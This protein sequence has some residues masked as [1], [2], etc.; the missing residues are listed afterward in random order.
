M[1]ERNVITR[2][3]GGGAVKEP[4][5][6]EG[7]NEER[8]KRWPNRRFDILI[9]PSRRRGGRVHF[10]YRMTAYS[11]LRQS[12]ASR[13]VGACSREHPSM[14]MSSTPAW[15]FLYVIST[16]ISRPSLHL[17]TTIFLDAE[18]HISTPVLA[19][20]NCLVVSHLSIS[21]R[22]RRRISDRRDFR[23]ST[24]LKKIWNNFLFVG[25]AGE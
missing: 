11:L 13:F 1:W 5:K 19:P 9:Y 2:V 25:S 3:K 16:S 4:E 22:E 24:I 17:R 15:R 6:K 7:G 12:N 21:Y 8:L 10:D 18:Y 23:K 20:V 14:R